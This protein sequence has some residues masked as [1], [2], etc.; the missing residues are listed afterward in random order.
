MN[1]RICESIRSLYTSSIYPN[2]PKKELCGQG[3]PRFSRKPKMPYI[4]IDYGNS[5]EIPNLLFISL[6]S[7][8]DVNLKN[9]HT[10]EEIRDDVK[11]NPPRNRFRKTNHWYQTFDI[12]TLL[13]DNYIDESIKTGVSYVDTFI[14]HTNAAKCTQ[15][16]EDRK[17]ADRILFNNCREFVQR[18]I[19]LFNADIIITQGVQARNTLRIF[20]IIEETERTILKTIHKEK[21]V[22]FEIFIREI[23][24]KKTLHIPMYHPSY[25]RGY[26]RHKKAIVDNLQLIIAI[27]QELRSNNNKV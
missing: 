22:N 24:G 3:L 27:M 25:Y 23:N 9:C 15:N 6:D 19:P 2:C 11:K 8:D 1:E 21:E 26:W 17:E 16:K 10:I 7:G 20:P 12:A 13:L 5:P 14:A 18:E 4:G